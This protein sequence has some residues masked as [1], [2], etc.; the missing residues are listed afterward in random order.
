MIETSLTAAQ[1]SRF[2]ENGFLV[3]EDLLSRE[4]IAT[5]AARTDL[6]AAGDAPHIPATSIQF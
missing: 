6:I 4:E 5:L 3:V 1:I 2:R